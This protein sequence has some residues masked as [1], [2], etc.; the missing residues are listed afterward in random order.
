KYTEWK[1]YEGNKYNALL[2][3]Y[4]PG[5]TVDIFDDVFGK[6]KA[7]LV[8]LLKEVV[9]ASNQPETAFLF[10]FFPEEKQAAFS[11]HILE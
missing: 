5:L 10:N 8:P 1:G 11:R 7:A 9:D 3:D 2:D 4:E 6:L